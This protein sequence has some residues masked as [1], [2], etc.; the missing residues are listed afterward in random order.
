MTPSELAPADVAP[1]LR[2]TVEILAAEIEALPESVFSW[3]PAPGEWCIKDVLGHLVEAELR[4]FAGRIR[5]VL[6]SDEPALETWDPAEVARARRD[7]ERDVRALLDELTHLRD[8]SVA[9]VESLGEAELLRAGRHPV[10][11]RLRVV[12][13]LHEW[14]HH[15]RNH[16]KQALSNV[17]AF[18]WPHLGNAQKFSQPAAG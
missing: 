2:A 11:G 8:A 13:L 5:I 18:V 12:D 15:D 14:V 4:G 1:L 17:Q 10:V 16:V 7:C 6:A 9:L 3:H